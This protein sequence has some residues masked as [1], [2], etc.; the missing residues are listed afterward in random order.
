VTPGFNESQWTDQEVGWALGRELIVIPVA[1]EDESPYG[2]LGTYQAVRRG[3]KDNHIALSRAV[4]RATTDAVFNAQRPAAKPLVDRAALMVANAFRRASSFES[5]R[6]WFDLLQTIPKSAWTAPV[7]DAVAAGL[8]DNR[9][10]Q[11]AILGDGRSLPDVVP[12][13]ID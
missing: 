4:F 8:A 5:A 10:L 3:P 11:E 1:V 2:F 9:Q 6:Y 7:R 13:L 12:E